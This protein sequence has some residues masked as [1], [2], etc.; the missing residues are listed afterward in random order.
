MKIKISLFALAFLFAP[1]C[2]FADVNKSGTL[3]SNETW[4]PSSG[5][6]VIT[7]NFTIPTGVTLTIDP[8][9]IVKIMPSGPW[10]QILF[11]VSGTLSSIGTPSQNITFTSYKDDIGGDTNGDGTTT[12][13][14]GDWAAIVVNSTG[15]ANFSYSKISYGGAYFNYSPYYADVYNDGGNLS[16]THSVI[17]S[18]ATSGI[19]QAGGMLSIAST[20]IQGNTVGINAF[21]ASTVSVTDSVFTNNTKAGTFSFQDGLRL[22]ASGDTA[23][24]TGVNGFGVSGTISTSQIWKADGIP[25][26][27]T[28]NFTIPTGVTLTL[29]PG[30]IVKIMPSGQWSQILFTVQGTL[31]A[32]GTPSQNITFTSYKDD[33]GG[34]TNGDGASSGSPGDW[35][36]IVVNSTGTANFSYSK[37]SYAGRGFSYGPYFADV[38]NDGGNLSLTN[39][40]ISSSENSG[41]VHA[42]GTT[43]IS[44]SS[45]RDN[46]GYGV[47]NVTTVVINAE[48]N[49]WG[50]LSGPRHASNPLGT[51]DRVSD[52]VNYTPYLKSDPTKEQETC[53]QD[54]Y[55]VMFIPGI[56]GS[57]LYQDNASTPLWFPPLFNP[58]N[59]DV[60]K[61]FLNSSGLSVRNDITTRDGEIVE[62]AYGQKDIY[63]GLPELLDSLKNQH[64]LADWKAISYD[65]RLDYETLLQNGKQTDNKI[66]YLEA[67][68]SPYILQELKRL[69]NE[70]G[71]HKVIIIAHSNGGLLVKALVKKLDESGSP[72]L[73]NIDQVVMIGTPQLGAPMSISSM[74]HGD[75]NPLTG[76][77]HPSMSDVTYRQFAENMPTMFNL[78]P[79]YAY[80]IP[81]EPYV[82]FDVPT[83]YAKIANKALQKY[84]S[85]EMDPLLDQMRSSYPYSTVTRDNLALFLTGEQ[86]G[87]A[88]PSADDLITPNILSDNLFGN[89]V[90]VH[91]SLDVYQFPASI[92]VTQIA[93]WGLPTISGI[94]YFRGEPNCVILGMLICKPTFELGR[95]PTTN[96]DGDGTVPT[97]SSL[98]ANDETKVFV[99]LKTYNID[100]S[101]T[102]E[103][104]IR[105]HKD[106]IG[107]QPVK[108]I[109]EHLIKNE[110]LAGIAYTSVSK[111][112]GTHY[113]MAEKHSPVD[114]DIY[115]ADGNHTGYVQKVID[116]VSVR[117]IEEN[118]PNSS[119]IVMGSSTYAIFPANEGGEV[120]LTGTGEGTMNFKL[121]EDVNDVETATT[122][123]EDIPITPS[124]SG[125]ITV[126]TVAD[127]TPLSI[128]QNGD[129]ITDLAID[130]V[131]NGTVII[132]EQKQPLTVTAK[133][134]TITLGGPIPPLTA[135]L[136][137]FTTDTNDVTGTP[138]C[139][140]TAT[141]DSP[142]GTYPITCA[143]GTLSSETYN[144]TSFV[145]GTLTISYR[146]DGF[147]Q[148][149]NDTTYHPEQ[150][151]SVFKGG[152]TVP[153]KFQ[154]KKSDG[155]PVS[156]KILPIF[157]SPQKGGAMSSPVDETTYTDTASNGTAFRLSDQQYIYNW[158]TKGLAVGYWYKLSAKLDDG[159]T[160]SVTVGLK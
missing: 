69:S 6:Y 97:W 154:L 7:D 65:W 34:D 119:Y 117:V 95:K 9:T 93:G 21:G 118:I 62:K 3:S 22:S 67:S 64:T 150:A 100:V 101:K 27:I 129:G 147:L 58:T 73:G 29:N 63:Q 85:Y 20:T 33:I 114:M 82:K 127:A 5:V 51:G 12:P 48:N 81:S 16:L 39:S 156:V 141:A 104:H 19:T 131:L 47:N 113:I 146:F 143:V 52:Y 30:T 56:A 59:S 76:L 130:P 37:I 123:F 137:G 111:P 158:S 94:E 90:S 79:S 157:L 142:V 49:Y 74:L 78:L 151:K 75:E 41:I 38:Y 126:D 132:P 2:A 80:N 92:K 153:V 50:A 10:S 149:I 160:Y 66:S 140:T 46:A 138:D 96:S 91:A 159:K 18:S 86:G 32:I 107:S 124:W 44:Q 84:G 98:S 109:L 125:S 77:S 54:C 36:A 28:E 26:V 70:A 133:N 108:N 15:T 60:E 112:S 40:I 31:S 4:S 122:A 68:S 55:S 103:D 1:A 35:A 99:D 53:V 89:S 128:D 134:Q 148:P 121:T 25:Y 13:N 155:T 42:G 14:P 139:T 83:G 17:S 43:N 120:K 110:S 152:S 8:G 24:G 115:D 71:T 45:I 145:P 72:L 61:L 57:Q 136:S 135:T 88:K 116:G 102:K 144:F 105:E 87:R 11:T 23:S 106:I